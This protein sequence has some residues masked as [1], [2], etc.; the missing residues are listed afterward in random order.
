MANS[1]PSEL[2]SKSQAEDFAASLR[3]E[4][5]RMREFFAEQQR[6]FEEAES[7][8]EQEILR[9]EATDFEASTASP[10]AGD[11]YRRR[12]EMALDDLRGLK[13]ENAE[14]QRQLANA[15]TAAP[16]AAHTGHLDW[17]SEKLRILAALEA[18]VDDGDA[19]RR[20][21]RLKIEDV[22]RATDH[23]LAQKDREIESLKQLL[24]EGHGQREADAQQTAAIDADAVVQEE[25][26]RLQQLENE[27]HEKVRQAEVDLSLERAKLARERLELANRIPSATDPSQ[28]SEG[29][30]A[31]G[32]ASRPARGRW[33]ARL[34]LSEADRV[35]RRRR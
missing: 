11:D 32:D 34:G 15:K 9:W 28:A 12:Y 30:N 2:G 21:E 27:W 25:R 16:I 7:L 1:L 20:A 33:L 26:L 10:T 17:E 31:A 18:G 3:A 23:I 19:D 4:Y 13:A 29:G 6:R 24:K 8:L 5:D 35:R 22:V 14:L